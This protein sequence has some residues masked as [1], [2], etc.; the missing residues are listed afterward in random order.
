VN[1]QH[2][3]CVV[4]LC[5]EAAERA[6]PAKKKKKKKQEADEEEQEVSA[7]RGCKQLQQCGR[8]RSSCYLLLGSVYA[9][10]RTCAAAGR[11]SDAVECRSTT[12][13]VAT[14]ATLSV[15]QYTL[16]LKG[17]LWAHQPCLADATDAALL[18]LMMMLMLLLLMLLL[19]Q[20]TI[21]REAVPDDVQQAEAAGIVL[22]VRRNAA[23]AA[24]RRIV[25]LVLNCLVCAAAGDLQ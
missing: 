3:W 9:V 1:P 15:A 14:A 11:G 6:G 21:M 22:V 20:A 25:M 10:F 12:H 13:P 23:A 5:R 16:D 24:V 8:G 7:V 19:L 18:L 4:V 2:R 17:Y